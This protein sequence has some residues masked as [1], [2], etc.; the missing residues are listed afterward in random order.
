MFPKV[1]RRLERQC[2]QPDTIVTRAIIS[3]F[4][5]KRSEAELWYREVIR[6]KSLSDIGQLKF[7]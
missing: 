7:I 2:D 1:T 5:I 6:F 3:F 4:F